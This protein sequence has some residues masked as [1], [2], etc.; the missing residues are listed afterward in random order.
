MRLMNKRSTMITQNHLR[1]DSRLVELFGQDQCQKWNNEN[2]EFL[3]YQCFEIEFGFALED[4]DQ[5]EE[6]TQIDE[7]ESFD[8]V[9]FPDDE[10]EL[11]SIGAFNP[12]RYNVR[13]SYLSR[14]YYRIGNSDK[15]LVLYSGEELRKVF[16]QQ[17]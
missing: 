5:L 6:G 4:L 11:I 8:P 16:N 15:I 17:S 1:I 3:R 7:L 12:M 13:R 14:K 10:L 9:N 2:P